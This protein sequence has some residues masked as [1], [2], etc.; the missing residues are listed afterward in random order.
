MKL[1]HEEIKGDLVKRKHW[2]NDVKDFIDNRLGC[3]LICFKLNFKNAILPE[4]KKR[5][6]K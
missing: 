3:E 5:I 2:R 1:L 6:E 4:L